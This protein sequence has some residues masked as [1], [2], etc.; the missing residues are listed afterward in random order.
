MC[1]AVECKQCGK[2][3]WAGCGR[4]VPEV[5]KSIPQHKVC[6]CKDWPGIS[7]PEQTSEEKTTDVGHQAAES[8]SGTGK[9]ATHLLETECATAVTL[10]SEVCS[11]FTIS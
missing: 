10:A 5:Y 6:L 9:S 11:L 7:F 2:T 1:Y 3:T 8:A 4:H